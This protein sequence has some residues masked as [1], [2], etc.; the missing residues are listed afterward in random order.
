M[1]LVQR[2]HRGHQADVWPRAAP[3]RSSRRSTPRRRRATG[4]C[5]DGV[6]L[7]MV[8]RRRDYR[9][10]H[11]GEHGRIALRSSCASARRPASHA[12]SARGQCHRSAESASLGRR[13]G[14]A[15]AGQLWPAA[16][17]STTSN[18]GSG[19]V[20]RACC[21]QARR[22][23]SN[24]RRSNS[25]GRKPGPG[26]SKSR[27]PPGWAPASC[28]DRV[29]P[30]RGRGIVSATART[31]ASRASPRSMARPD[32]PDKPAA[33][34]GR[35]PGHGGFPLAGGPTG[36]R[37]RGRVQVS[38]QLPDRPADRRMPHF[39]GHFGGRLEHESRNAIRGCGT[40]GSGESMTCS[41]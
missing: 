10:L 23:T 17:S 28:H 3:R 22:K 27:S 39:G 13:S 29:R 19:D 33:R 18:F 34:S 30:R 8:R 31:L 5:G 36:P 40:V 6:C 26:R 37:R 12:R 7:F 14:S 1:P 21:S 20:S 4:S 41:P 35:E 2:A 9:S 25:A 11:G 24:R 16:S 32:R 38:Q 15:D